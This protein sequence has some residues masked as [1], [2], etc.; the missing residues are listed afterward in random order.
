MET[1]R[2][3]YARTVLMKLLPRNTVKKAKQSI[4][5]ITVMDQGHDF[6]PFATLP[7]FKDDD[8]YLI[9]FQQNSDHLFTGVGLACIIKGDY[10]TE[11]NEVIQVKS[12]KLDTQK[13]LLPIVFS[14]KA[15]EAMERYSISVNEIKHEIY[16]TTFICFNRTRAL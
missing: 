5:L 16:K 2:R 1:E 9:I 15:N 13:V 8:E 10:L 11:K 14:K 4:Y 12:K 7:F 3:R 6:I